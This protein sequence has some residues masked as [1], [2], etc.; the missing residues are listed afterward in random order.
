MQNEVVEE[1]FILC[2]SVYIKLDCTSVRSQE[3]YLSMI[4]S[5]RGHLQL[6]SVREKLH[7]LENTEQNRLII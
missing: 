5:T 4:N 3:H 7:S 1:E 6:K 2:Q